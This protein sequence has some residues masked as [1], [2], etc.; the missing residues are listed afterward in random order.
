MHDQNS[1]FFKC[2]KAR[3][4]PRCHFLDAVMSPNSS[5]V[6]LCY[7]KMDKIGFLRKTSGQ[8]GKFAQLPM[9]TGN[10]LQRFFAMDLL[11]AFTFWTFPSHMTMQLFGKSNF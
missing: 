9:V 10:A 4:F 11:A 5:F 7:K 6:K 2:F 1:L 8:F 3:Y